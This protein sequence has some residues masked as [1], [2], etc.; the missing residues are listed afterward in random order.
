MTFPSH[1]LSARRLAIISVAAPSLLLAACTSADL[2][3]DGATV[4]TAAMTGAAEAPGPGDADGSGS[5]T[6]RIDP[7]AASRLCFDLSVTGIAPAT[8]AHIHRGGLGVPGPVVVPLTPPTAGSSA[9]CV[10]IAA[11]LGAEILAMPAGFYVNVH[12]AP[13]PDGAV[14][15][16]LVN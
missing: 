5:A 7:L 15:G 1:P 3:M 4:L 12:N 10:D 14:R 16:Q 8:A 11:T 6:V 2:N 9:G 13:Y